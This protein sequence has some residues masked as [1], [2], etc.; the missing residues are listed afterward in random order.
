V[1]LQMLKANKPVNIGDHI[2]YVI[3]TQGPEGSQAAQRAYHPD[4]VMRA[5][6]GE[7]C[8]LSLYLSLLC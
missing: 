5:A 3:C 1:A 8:S 6:P 2:P 4:D 7:F